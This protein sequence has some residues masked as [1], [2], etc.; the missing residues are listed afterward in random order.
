[1]DG[2][3]FSER[4]VKAVCDDLAINLSETSPR[5]RRKA[6]E[7]LQTTK[8]LKPNFTTGFI[9]IY[10]LSHWTTAKTLWYAGECSSNLSRCLNT[11]VPPSL[12]I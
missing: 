10:T 12:V 11:A 7:L 4:P 6:G 3:R 2:E 9:K 1:M 5:R 8:K